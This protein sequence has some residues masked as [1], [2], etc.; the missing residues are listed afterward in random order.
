MIILFIL[1]VEMDNNEDKKYD[2]NEVDETLVDTIAQYICSR[3]I[4]YVL[5]IWICII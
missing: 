1:K 2:T 4:E 5:S 3:A